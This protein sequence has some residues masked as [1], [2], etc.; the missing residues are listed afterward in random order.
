MVT[1]A[2]LGTPTQ[3]SILAESQPSPQPSS[4]NTPAASETSSGGL[5]E[6]QQASLKELGIPI[7]VPA[8]VPDGFQVS[9]IDSN[10]CRTDPKPDGCG[11]SPR[12]SIVYKNA[13]SSCLI[14][15][16]LGSGVGGA[17]SEF[18]FQV[19]TPLLGKVDIGFGQL[20]GAGKPP[21]NEQLTVPQSGLSSFPAPLI[22]KRSPYYNVDAGNPADPN[23]DYYQTKYGCSRNP[24]I[25][26]AELEKILQSLVILN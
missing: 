4:S 11:D 7:L 13:Q 23:Y 15:N 26:P 16:A 6:Q 25:T 24:S 9:Q 8:S 17:D 21:T 1:I 5:S 18:T 12:Y 20:P 10:S 22:A 14:V 2:S 19:D 3:N